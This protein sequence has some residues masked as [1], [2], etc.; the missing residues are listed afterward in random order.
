M[1]DGARLPKPGEPVCSLSED[2]SR[3]IQGMLRASRRDIERVEIK[4]DTE[5]NTVEI[6]M[7]ALPLKKLNYK[8][9]L[10]M[11]DAGWKQFF[12][13]HPPLL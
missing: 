9:A 5:P 6:K 4:T 8:D 12:A 10:A 1:N 11:D 13:D 3:M 2:E 7:F